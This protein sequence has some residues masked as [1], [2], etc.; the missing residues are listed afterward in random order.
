MFKSAYGFREFRVVP[1]ELV[2]VHVEARIAERQLE[3]D[4]S[5][6]LEPSASQ[7]LPPK[8]RV[9]PGSACTQCMAQ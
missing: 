8:L 1:W 5:V 4:I 9:N 7:Q 2:L 6:L 3:I